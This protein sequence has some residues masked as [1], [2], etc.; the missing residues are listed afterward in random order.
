MSY[1]NNKLWIQNTAIFLLAATLQYGFKC[2]Y[3][4]ILFLRYLNEIDISQY[5]LI[6][7]P[8]L[9]TYLRIIEYIYENQHEMSFDLSVISNKSKYCSTIRSYIS[10]LVAKGQ[11]NAALNLAKITNTSCDFIIFNQLNNEFGNASSR[12]EEY[13][14]RWDKIFEEYNVSPD[15]IVDKYL[16]FIQKSN[17]KEEIFIMYKLAFN[18]TSNYK[19]ENSLD[20]EK[21]LWISYFQLDD[22]SKRF[23]QILSNEEF[24]TLSDYSKELQIIPECYNSFNEIEMANFEKIIDYLLD[25]EDIITALRLEKMFGCTSMDL[26]I[27]KLCLNLVEGAVLPHQL[28]ARQRLLLNRRNNIKSSASIR[29]KTYKTLNRISSCAS[30]KFS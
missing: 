30:G 17:D 8:D 3:D 1:F 21:E 9:K 14:R 16:E 10:N 19:L 26:N 11:Y 4:Q 5:F 29:R 15:V 12:N 23:K 20:V 28:T 2:F 24:T 25:N 7:I 13:W 6:E 22:D 27:L 18:W